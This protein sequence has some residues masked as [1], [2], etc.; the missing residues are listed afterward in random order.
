MDQATL[1]GILL[2]NKQLANMSDQRSLDHG[3]WSE[4]SGEASFRGGIVTADQYK[5]GDNWRKIRKIKMPIFSGTDPDGWLFH[6]ERYFDING[7]TE[8]Q[9]LGAVGVSLDGDALSWLQW[10]EARMPFQNWQK[11]RHQL[12]LRFRST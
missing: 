7:L 8:Q 5:R 2:Q 6:A 10:I 11:F 4:G 9:K 12:L 3:K 1:L